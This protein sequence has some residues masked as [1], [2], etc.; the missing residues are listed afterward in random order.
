MS[1]SERFVEYATYPLHEWLRGRS[2]L[3]VARE[4]QLLAS[5]SPARVEQASAARLRALLVFAAARLP[6][7]QRLFARHAVDPAADDPFVELAKLPVLDKPDVRAHATEMIDPGVPGGLIP[8]S[9][10]GTT[11]DKLHFYIDRARQAHQLGCRLFMQSL[12]GVRSGDRRVYLWGSPIEARAPW[13]KRWRDRLINERVLDAFDMSPAVT[14]THLATIRSLRPRVIYGYPSA[15][16]LLARHIANRF[17]PDDFPWLRLVV[18]TGEEVTPAQVQEVRTTFGCAV[19]S[20]Y[21]SREV[22]LIAHECPHGSL[23]VVSPHV[24]VEIAADGVSAPPGRAGEVLCTTLMTRAQPFIRYRLGDVGVL[25]PERCRCGLPLPRMRLL[26]GKVTGFIVL[27]DGRLCH[28]AVTSHVLRNER[29]IVEFKTYQRAI[30]RFEVLLVV[31]EGF[32]PAATARIRQRYGALFGPHVDV[33]CRVVDR[34]PP[35]PSGKRRYVV[36]DVASE[37]AIANLGS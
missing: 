23:H 19:A 16:A 26:G 32:E 27:R 3:A 36:S 5:R 1:V 15:L 24:H 25:E 10:G 37:Q 2:T 35:D 6:Y 9:S 20:E 17:G 34:I 14:A 33:D 30:D 4:L 13:I 18:L 31:G 12:F 21:G 22:G 11:G 28:G 8:H 29:G 7:Y